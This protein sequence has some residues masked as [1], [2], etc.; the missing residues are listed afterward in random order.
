MD[1]SG[2]RDTVKGWSPA[3]SDVLFVAVEDS[4]DEVAGQAEDSSADADDAA[5]RTRRRTP[6]SRMARRRTPPTRSPVWL[7]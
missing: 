4:A 2:L 1:I 7:R 5:A 3:L 6:R